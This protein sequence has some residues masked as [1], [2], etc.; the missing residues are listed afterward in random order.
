MLYSGFP[1][2]WH[3]RT[4]IRTSF[5][6]CEPCAGAISRRL[7]QISFDSPSQPQLTPFSPYGNRILE[8]QCS[9]MPS[10][11]HEQIQVQTKQLESKN[12]TKLDFFEHISPGYS[13]MLSKS[14]PQALPAAYVDHFLIHSLSHCPHSLHSFSRSRRSCL[15]NLLAFGPPAWH[16]FHPLRRVALLFLTSFGPLTSRK[17]SP[18]RKY[19]MT[20]EKCF[21]Q[22]L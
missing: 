14:C 7:F 9:E 15:L 5:S 4:Y 21:L 20:S 19:R 6:T 22:A 17:L 8:V 18:R 3:V 2:N 12:S 10:E 16:C 1:V 11:F 13:S